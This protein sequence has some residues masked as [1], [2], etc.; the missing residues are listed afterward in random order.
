MGKFLIVKCINDDKIPL[1]IC[2]DWQKWQK[3]N[4]AK[5][6]YDFIVYKF[7]YDHFEFIRYCE[8]EDGYREVICYEK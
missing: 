3:E 4:K 2:D 6:K 1:T 7:R 5:I 8:Y